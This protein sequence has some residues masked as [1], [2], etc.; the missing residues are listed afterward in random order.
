MAEKT[1]LEM[2][3]AEKVA[4]DLMQLIADKEAD[5]E[6][7]KFQKPDVRTYY[8]TLF[9]QCVKASHGGRDMKDVLETA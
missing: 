2:D 6:N 5:V 9:H 1:I 8:L 7:T 3:S 4:Y